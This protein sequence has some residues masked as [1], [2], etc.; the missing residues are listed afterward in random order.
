[1]TNL[2]GQSPNFLH[3]LRS[4]TA[5]RLLN[6]PIPRKDDFVFWYKNSLLP[7][8]ISELPIWMADKGPSVWHEVTLGWNWEN[9][10]DTPHWIISQPHCDGATA[11][12]IFFHAACLST[13]GDGSINER[14]NLNH[15]YRTLCTRILSLWRHRYYTTRNFTPAFPTPPAASFR[16]HDL[17]EACGDGVVWKVPKDMYGPFEG[18]ET[19]TDYVFEND[20]IRL[21][22]HSVYWHSKKTKLLTR[23]RA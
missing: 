12:H 17:A 1:M 18:Q 3:A 2:T 6:K 4:K 22:P 9:G 8:S 20:Q 19:R 16:K 7:V 5:A 21:A 15:R 10:L 14:E 11:A 23:Y 13:L